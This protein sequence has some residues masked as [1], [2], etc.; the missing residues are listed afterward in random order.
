MGLSLNIDSSARPFFKPL[1]VTSFVMESVKLRDLSRPL[2]DA[3]RLKALRGITVETKHMGYRKCYK[4]IGISNEPANQIMFSLGNEESELFVAQYFREKY[5]MQLKFPALPC[6]QVGSS[7]KPTYI[8]MED[9]V[10]VEI[11]CSVQYRVATQN[12]DDE[13][14]ELMNPGEQ[15][16]EYVFD[17]VRDI[18]PKMNYTQPLER[19][20]EVAISLSEELQMVMGEYGYSLENALITNIVRKVTEEDNRQENEH[21]VR[22]VRTS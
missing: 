4:V 7:K 6:I 1:C 8:P 15:I 5:K 14:Y 11:E 3:A 12:D 10:E 22:T 18:V 17:V 2:N 9:N 19:K 16:Q 13:Y 20:Y 21:S